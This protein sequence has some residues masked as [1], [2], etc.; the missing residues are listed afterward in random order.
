VFNVKLFFSIHQNWKEASKLGIFLSICTLFAPTSSGSDSF[1]RLLAKAAET[2]PLVDARRRAASAAA[3]DKSVAEWAYYPSLSYSTEDRLEGKAQ[4]V[5]RIDMPLLSFGRLASNASASEAALNSSRLSIEEV[6]LEVMLD[7]TNAYFALLSSTQR[8]VVASQNVAEHKRLMA[9]IDR[10]VEAT[11]SPKAD[12]M[13]AQARLQLAA[14]NL[15]EVDNEIQIARAR[16]EQYIGSYEG[17]V[18]VP[19]GLGPVSEFKG[20]VDMAVANSPTLRRLKSDEQ[21]LSARQAEQYADLRPEF[22]LGYEKRKG[23]FQLFQRDEEQVFV[24]FRYVTGA[25]MSKWASAK[26]AEQRAQAA[27]MI[28]H[29]TEREVRNTVQKLWSAYHTYVRQADVLADLVTA[30]KSVVDSYL[31]QYIVGRKSWLDVMN[32][33]REWT[34]ARL[35]EMSNLAEKTGAHVSIQLYTGELGLDRWVNNSE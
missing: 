27:Q 21:V 33:Q 11:A 6:Q 18:S 17:D 9:I 31:R 20:L 23:S 15:I 2:Y 26:A 5:T 14:S 3:F 34:S 25:G 8:R 7:V 32:A 16:I 4:I 22:S 13:L 12:L 30:S 24:T 28:S 35:A 19:A 10:R 1:Y 29:S